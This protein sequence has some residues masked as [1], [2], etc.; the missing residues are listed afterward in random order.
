VDFSLST[1]CFLPLRSEDHSIPF[2]FS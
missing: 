2:I 1:K